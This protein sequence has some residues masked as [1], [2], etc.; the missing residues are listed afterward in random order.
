MYTLEKMKTSP[1]CIQMMFEYI[2]TNHLFKNNKGCALVG[3]R[4]HGMPMICRPRLL[5]CKTNLSTRTTS[6][7]HLLDV[8]VICQINLMYPSSSRFPSPLRKVRGCKMSTVIIVRWFVSSNHNVNIAKFHSSL[9]LDTRFISPKAKNKYVVILQIDH[10]S[11]SVMIRF[12][13]NM[14]SL[15]L[16]E[17]ACAMR[18]NTLM[19]EGYTLGFGIKCLLTFEYYAYIIC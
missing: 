6:Y 18:L 2:W 17:E 8:R 10:F 4:K 11:L 19:M 3:T 14:R 15:S 12:L 13:W 5:I 1:L 7:G 16:G 9:T